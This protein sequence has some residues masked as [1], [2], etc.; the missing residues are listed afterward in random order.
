MSDHG[1]RAL[2][3]RA[4]AM[5]RFRA[6]PERPSAGRAALLALV[7][8][9]AAAGCTPTEQ[10][11]DAEYAARMAA[12]HRGD[13]PVAAAAAAAGDAAELETAAVAYASI[14]G[15]EV[16]GYLARPAG[17]GPL[18]GLLVIQE[19]WGL[20]DNMRAMA[21]R[22]AGEGYVALAVDLYD[23]QVAE[24]AETARR[25]MGEAMAREAWLEENLRQA[26]AYLVR[27]TAA[28][29]VGVIGWCF[30]GGWSLRAALSMPD[31]IEAAVIYYGRLI[32]EPERLAPL[33]APIL[34]IFGAEDRGIPV[35]SVRAFESV[36]AELGRDV[37]IHVYDGADHAFANP[38][39]TRYEPT[40]AEDAW[41]RTTSFFATHLRP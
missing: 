28:P 9:F 15:G 2:P 4:A 32:V 29:R 10:S 22:L 33:R 18:P 16:T 5:Q 1:S 30:G 20:N 40:A 27:E 17:S 11:D 36:L 6:G 37:S 23:G 41:Q 13:Q 38:S 26:R 19:W 7:V 25:L 31:G 12:E 14:D 39:G 35:E 3:P 34:G 8:L 21:R 24:D